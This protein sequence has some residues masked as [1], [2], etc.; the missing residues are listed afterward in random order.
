MTTV[1]VPTSSGPSPAPW[2][3]R[4][5][6]VTTRSLMVDP[7]VA[8]GS[9]K[10]YSAAELTA[11][12]RTVPEIYRRLDAGVSRADL[13][14]SRTSADPQE[15]QVGQT[16]AHLFA[17]SESAQPLS[18][19]LE[20]GKLNVSAGHHRTRS[21]QAAGVD[22]LPVFVR[23]RTEAELD[24]LQQ[25]LRTEQGPAYKQAVRAHRSE[26]VSRSQLRTPSRDSDPQSERGEVR[27]RA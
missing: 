20:D 16:F 2:A 1:H 25:H 15:R 18:A 14:A 23:A 19:D 22:V 17:A 11:I 4:F 13:L 21:A 27:T 24:S 9:P 6:P 7:A 8:A 3:S 10:G 12:V 26:A 5:M